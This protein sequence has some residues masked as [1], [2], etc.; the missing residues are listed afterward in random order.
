MLHG[1]GEPVTT[2]HECLPVALVVGGGGGGGGVI[3]EIIVV[4]AHTPE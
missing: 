3:Q 4:T 1:P 2:Q